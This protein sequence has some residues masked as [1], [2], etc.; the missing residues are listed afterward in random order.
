MVVIIDEKRERSEVTCAIVKVRPHRG[1]TARGAYLEERRG[2]RVNALSFFRGRSLL[3]VGFAV[4]ASY[5]Q[6][7]SSIPYT[8]PTE[9]EI[10]THNQ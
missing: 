2:Q 6:T 5:L 3:P 10:S 8:L 7:L 9:D 1:E 4:P